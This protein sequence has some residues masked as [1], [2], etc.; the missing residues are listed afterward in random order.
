MD[1]VKERTAQANRC[2]DGQHKFE[3]RL[4]RVGVDT[5]RACGHCGEVVTIREA[6]RQAVLRRESLAAK[7]ADAPDS[8]DLRDAMVRFEN[9][10]SLEDER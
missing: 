6:Q 2:R 9:A 1:D 3:G 5:A 8:D 4:L 10:R 7:P